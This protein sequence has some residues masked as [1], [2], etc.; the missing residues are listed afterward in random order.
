MESIIDGILAS[1]ELIS[2]QLAPFRAELGIK[3][4]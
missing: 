4:G 3:A 1:A 2:Y